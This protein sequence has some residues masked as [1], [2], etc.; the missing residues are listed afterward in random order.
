MSEIR[1]LLRQVQGIASVEITQGPSGAIA[2]IEI[3][4]SPQASE[5]RV[6]R[7]VESAL[8]SGLG[9]HIDHRAINIR[10]TSND[11]GNGANRRELASQGTSRMAQQREAKSLSAR[12]LPDN[13][14][15]DERVRLEA[16]RCHPD[17]ELYC[18][19]TVELQV[20]GRWIE[21][22]IREADTHRGRLL[23]AGRA[24]V[25]AI[26]DVIEEEAAIA[27]E[28]VEEFT[29]CEAT[30][31]LAV[32]RIR[33]RRLR[34]D[35]YGAALIEDSPEEAAARAVL[36]ALNRFLESEEPRTRNV[37]RKVRG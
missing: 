27:L 2:G 29:I 30:G 9:L 10:R 13:D 7:D 33:Q 28:G 15:A 21:R 37:N 20:A 34:L 4:V 24:T 11:V 8:M 31:L 36:D 19:V 23:A 18:D 17:G 32:L 22:T 1:E 26:A 5:R 25:G 16:V 14:Q 12:F 35:F 6:V 3:T